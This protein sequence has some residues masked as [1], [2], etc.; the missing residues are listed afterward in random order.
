M[1]KRPAILHKSLEKRFD[2]S[3]YYMT[4]WCG[5]WL[6]RAGP[7]YAVPVAGLGRDRQRYRLTWRAVTCKRCLKGKR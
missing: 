5:L 1:R 6:P 4:T 7:D 3:G 2:Y